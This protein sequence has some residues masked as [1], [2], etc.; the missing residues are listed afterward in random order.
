MPDCSVALQVSVLQKPA[1]LPLRFW[2]WLGSTAVF[3]GNGSVIL[4]LKFSVVS[5][6]TLGLKM[7]GSGRGMLLNL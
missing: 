6:A 2:V 4:P 5:L 1:A 7:L 3:P